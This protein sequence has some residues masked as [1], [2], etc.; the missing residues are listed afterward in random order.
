VRLV[1][2]LAAGVAAG[3]GATALCIRILRHFAV[4]DV[5]NQRSSHV[6]PTPRGGGVGFAVGTLTGLAVGRL[7]GLAAAHVG[8]GAF[9][10]LPPLLVCGLGFAALGFADDLTSALSARVRLAGQ[11][12]LAVAVVAVAAGDVP[13]H[14]IVA[15]VIGAAA[16]A[17]IVSY[18]NAFN[19]MDGINGISVAQIVVAGAAIGLVARHEHHGG[20]EV[21]SL[22]LGAGAL[23]FAPFN[24][25][26]AAIFLGDVGSYFAGA[27][28]AVLVLAGLDL[29]VPAE[30]VIAPVALY[31]ADTGVTLA[32]RVHR[33][34][35]WYAPHRQHT[36][37]RLVDQGWSQPAT[38]ALVLVLAATCS[39]LGAVS[40]TGSLP[41]RVGADC[42]GLALIGGYL[43]LPGA[44][45]RRSHLGADRAD[46]TGEGGRSG[47]GRRGVRPS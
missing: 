41:W 7:T 27:W 18:V 33:H 11:A 4:L 1:V 14:G 46:G 25:P 45:G 13:G 6:R 44:L 28:L 38:S 5:P 21:A 40:L 36:Y 31:L 22:A 15:V 37:Q 29:G 32:R 23:G 2:E 42:T 35:R 19:F 9:R 10:W 3:A 17:W 34:E 30:A 8:L 24:F 39:A 26:R 16:A 20:L 43:A 47:P 12:L